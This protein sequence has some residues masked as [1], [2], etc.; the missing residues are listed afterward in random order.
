MVGDDVFEIGVGDHVVMTL[1]KSCGSC[2]NCQSGASVACTD[3]LITGT[4]PIDEIN[5]TIASVKNGHAVRN[6]ILF[7]QSDTTGAG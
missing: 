2:H 6:V 5:E 1:I 7:D 4:Y 3:E